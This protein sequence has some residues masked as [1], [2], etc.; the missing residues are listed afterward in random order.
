M[1]EIVETHPFDIGE[2]VHTV[3]NTEEIPMVRMVVGALP[4]RVLISSSLVT[5]HARIP[6]CCLTSSFDL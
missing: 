6:T 3:S 5:G 4:P 1:T 2:F